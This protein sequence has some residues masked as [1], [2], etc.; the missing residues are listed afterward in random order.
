LLWRAC[1]RLVL[2]DGFKENK[3]AKWREK[4]KKYVIMFSMLLISM[5]LVVS[6]PSLPIANAAITPYGWNNGW[7]YA[8]LIHASD[9]G[10]DQEPLDKVIYD[11]IDNLDKWCVDGPF[12][13]DDYYT[14]EYYSARATVS[15]A[16]AS[17][18]IYQYLPTSAEAR[19][20]AHVYFTDLNI[21]YSSSR[22]EIMYLQGNSWENQVVASITKVSGTYRW[23]LE[24]FVGGSLNLVQSTSIPSKDDWYEV[25]LIRDLT[26]NQAQLLIDGSPVATQTRTMTQNTLVAGFGIAYQTDAGSNSVCVDDIE[27]Y[28]SGNPATSTANL[29]VIDA[30]DDIF[31][32]F[33]NT[34]EYGRLENYLQAGRSYSTVGN[35]LGGIY[36]DDTDYPESTFLY[37]GHN[38]WETR[39]GVTHYGF[40]ENGAGTPV[41]DVGKVW[42][43]DVYDNIVNRRHHFVFLWV[44]RNG[45]ALGGP[46][47]PYPP[48]GM[49]YC[50]TH[51]AITNTN[52]YTG[53]DWSGYWFI[54]FNSASPMLCQYI[55]PSNSNQLYKHWLVFFYHYAVTVGLTIN[56]AIDAASQASGY[57]SFNTFPSYNGDNGNTVWWN[58]A[59]GQ[60]P[61]W[62]TSKIR[63]YGDGTVYL[64]H[65]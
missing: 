15:T 14:S 46:N 1:H 13:E 58:G 62:I 19:A 25:E 44:C 33:S 26:T 31:S 24:T 41:G 56:Q 52:A 20:I 59:D 47:S 49:P 18:K 6:L 3:L 28:A 45:E 60:P 42:D 7:G 22:L 32:M 16:G 5:S 27:V 55:S 12:L 39:E 10:N 17:N 48:Y 65:V 8:S 40:A 63:V 64:P 29:A 37:I 4:K 57:S 61:S 51:G 30:A 35:M 43:E 9:A 34:L 23:T 36:E 50:W 38:G 2:I 11:E 53:N 21:P 54:S